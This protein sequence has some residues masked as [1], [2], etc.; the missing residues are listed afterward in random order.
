MV[1]IVT[2]A[3]Q[4]QRRQVRQ[5]KRWLPFAR[6]QSARHKL[7]AFL[8]DNGAEVAGAAGVHPT[9]SGWSCLRPC[10]RCIHCA[11]GEGMM[12]NIPPHL[13]CLEAAGSASGLK[14]EVQRRQGALCLSQAHARAC[15]AGSTGS[16]ASA[17]DSRDSGDEQR[18]TTIVINCHD[19]AGLLAD[20]A[21]TVHK[22]G[23]NLM[24]RWCWL[25]PLIGLCCW[26]ACAC[27][28]AHCT[29][30]SPRHAH[31]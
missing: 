11:S 26:L 23:L 22:H 13:P 16:E 17:S 15:F 9:S 3:T 20:V 1:D 4:S 14:L 7:R 25:L 5:H 19:R 31:R 21:A 24:V 29:V 12:H 10:E 6:T 18:S 27:M 28:P 8:R 30:G 2:A